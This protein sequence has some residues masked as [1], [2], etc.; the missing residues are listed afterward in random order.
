VILGTVAIV[1]CFTSDR[2]DWGYR[3]ALSY[4]ER[5]PKPVE[6]T[7]QAQPGLWKPAGLILPEQSLIRRP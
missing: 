7:N 1:G 6:V 5:F 3:W 4:P 2:E